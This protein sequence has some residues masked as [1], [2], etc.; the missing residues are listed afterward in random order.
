[1]IVFSV[2]HLI[3]QKC[4]ASFGDSCKIRNPSTSMNIVIVYKEYKVY[5]DN[6]YKNKDYKDKFYNDN[7]YLLHA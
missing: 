3:L 5:E 2:R 7:V 4:N 1:M 6:A